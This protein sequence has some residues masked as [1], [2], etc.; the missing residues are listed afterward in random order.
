MQGYSQIFSFIL[1]VSDDYAFNKSS[2]QKNNYIFENAQVAVDGSRDT[3]SNTT[4]AS[5]P[6]WSVDLGRD[7]NIEGM[8]IYLHQ[9]TLGL[10]HLPFSNSLSRKIHLST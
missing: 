8:V 3:C 1:Y 7:M 5:D 9:Q 4:L 10:F 2:N 6:W